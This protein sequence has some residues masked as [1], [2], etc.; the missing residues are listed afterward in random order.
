[1]AR[2]LGT[3]FGLL[4]SGGTSDAGGRRLLAIG[5]FSWKISLFPGKNRGLSDG[6]D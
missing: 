5:G 4:T 6:G 3:A 1:M 2:N